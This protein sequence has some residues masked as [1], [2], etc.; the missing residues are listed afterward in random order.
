M[1]NIKDLVNDTDLLIY[2]IGVSALYLKFFDNCGESENPA[3]ES[4]IRKME[5]HFEK[6]QDLLLEAVLFQLLSKDGK[7]IPDAVAVNDISK[8]LQQSTICQLALNMGQKY[9]GN[10]IWKN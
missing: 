1:K 2:A 6:G 5:R 3:I 10:S 7:S 8:K 4:E 9:S